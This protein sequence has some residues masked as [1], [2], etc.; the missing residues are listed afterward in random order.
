MAALAETSNVSKA[1]EFA[2]I[3]VSYV[4]KLRRSDGEFARKWRLALF[5]GYE[6]L[7]MLVL[8]HL[9]GETEPDLKFDI[10]NALRVLTAHRAEAARE[11]AHAEGEDEKAVLDSI[12]RFLD[13]MRERAAANAALLADDDVAS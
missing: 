8:C 3:T 6:H 12:D 11:R 5:E 13:D 10:A 7:E 1:A 2:N 9:R 4:Y